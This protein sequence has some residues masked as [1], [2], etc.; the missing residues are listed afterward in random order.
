MLIPL[1]KEVDKDILNHNQN[2]IVR[3]SRWIPANYKV[4]KILNAFQ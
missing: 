3:H 4:M 2:T 1:K